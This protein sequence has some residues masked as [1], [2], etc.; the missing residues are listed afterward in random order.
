MQGSGSLT[1]LPPVLTIR[2]SRREMDALG[3]EYAEFQKQVEME[4]QLAEEEAW[5]REQADQESEESLY[6][7]TYSR[8][9][10]PENLTGQIEII[11]WR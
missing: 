7:G 1:S 11:N 8:N 6:E 10:H 9:L 4:E 3:E 5:E 2:M